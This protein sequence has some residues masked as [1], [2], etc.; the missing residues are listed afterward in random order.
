[1]ISQERPTLIARSLAEVTAPAVVVGV[2]AGPDGPLLLTDALPDEAAV[3]LESSLELLEVKGRPDEVHRLP[4]LSGSRWPLLVLVGLGDLDQDG[5]ADDEALRQAS[6]AA[7]RSLAG[8]E[9]VAL[10]LPA[11]TPSRLAAVAEGAALGAYAFTAFTSAGD[12]PGRAPVSTVEL[13]TPLPASASEPVLR[14]AAVIGDAVCAVRDL[15]NTPPSHLYPASFADAV[16]GDLEGTDVDVRV[17]DEAQ[18]AAEGF[19][20]IVGIGQGSSRP[21]RLVRVEHAPAGARA[22]VALVG[23]GI[24][25]DTGGISLKP[26]ASMMTMKSDMAGAATV[27]A[28]VRAAAALEIPVRVTGWLAMA[29]NMPSDT[30]LRPSD[31]L[32]M[33]GG[34][35]VEVMNTD[36]EGRVVMAD[37]LVAATD[38]R[39]DAVLDVATLTG[40]QLVAL[41]VRHTGVMGDEALRNEVVA[42]AGAAGELAWPMPIPEQL[43]P[44]LDSRVADIS[45]MGERFGGMMT[46]AAFLREF[47]DA[48]RPA[49][50]RAESPTPWAH[51]DIAGPSFNE[52]AAYGYTP[53]DATGTM[54]RT[55]VGLIAGRAG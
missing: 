16:V 1:M 12:T 30:A 39:P 17:W 21:P 27:F 53:R 47:V 36:A 29:E 3:A 24:T 40:A 48:G 11:D 54:V 50:E 44:S 52:S 22:H 31:V 37:A 10:A 55:L 8:T 51:L 7:V 9:S 25:F 34:K 38:E 19:G 43:R 32:T 35:T 15:V 28:V 42:A 49:A 6:G 2:G 5:G 14:R 46:A 45:N 13:V 4:G 23:K 18:L 20:G 41:G 26:P 33:H